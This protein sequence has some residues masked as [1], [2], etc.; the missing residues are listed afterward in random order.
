MAAVAL[1]ALSLSVALLAG[2]LL[3]RG[4]DDWWETR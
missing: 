4:R 3:R 1:L 2:H